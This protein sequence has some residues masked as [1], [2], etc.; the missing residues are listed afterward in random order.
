[1]K[2][3][4]HGETKNILLVE[5]VIT[6]LNPLIYLTKWPEA[7]LRKTS[8]VSVGLWPQ[9]PQRLSKKTEELLML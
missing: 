1:M 7:T 6:E 2:Q 3:M 9:Y 8:L 4:I 5:P